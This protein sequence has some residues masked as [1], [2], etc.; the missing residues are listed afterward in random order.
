[1]LIEKINAIFPLCYRIFFQPFPILSPNV[2][3]TTAENSTIMITFLNALGCQLLF[4]VHCLPNAQ[5]PMTLD[6]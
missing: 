6:K 1:M 5:P 3:S 2:H 4:A